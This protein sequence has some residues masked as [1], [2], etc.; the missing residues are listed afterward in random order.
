MAN[1]LGLINCLRGLK[2]I[3]NDNNSLDFSWKNLKK[4]FK[5]KLRMWSFKN[6][7]VVSKNSLSFKSY[8]RNGYRRS[9]FYTF[10]KRLRLVI[11]L[12]LTYFFTQN[13]ILRRV[14]L[15]Y[16]KNISK[17]NSGTKLYTPIFTPSFR[18]II[19]IHISSNSL[20]QKKRQ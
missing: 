18:L 7:Q 8:C 1:S 3:K 9:L 17:P 10:S 13:F 6:I 4:S 16:R 20:R 15:R 2:T 14:I 12:Q 11:N 19:G 5:F